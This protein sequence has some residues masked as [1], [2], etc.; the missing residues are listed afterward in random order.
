MKQTKLMLITMSLVLLVTGCSSIFTS[1]TNAEIKDAIFASFQK[2][3]NR[4]IDKLEARISSGAEKPPEDTVDDA[5][6]YKDLV[7]QYGG[8]KGGGAILSDA[9]RIGSLTFARNSMYYKWVKGGC[10]QLGAKN[11]TDPRQTMCC[12]F[13]EGADGVWRGGK[14]DW[15]STSRTSRELKHI[16]RDPKYSNWGD[17]NLTSPM[18]AVFVIV[19]KGGRRSNVI[20]GTYVK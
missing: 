9:V 6:P 3:F 18:E 11:A 13:F 14:W 20:R 10:E 5:V 17:F 1:E 8:F 2:E 4:G 7:W 19:S 16:N 12:I 15:I